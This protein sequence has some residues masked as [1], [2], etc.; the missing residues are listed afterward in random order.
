MKRERIYHPLDLVYLLTLVVTP[1]TVVIFCLGI[2]DNCLLAFF[3]R[4][5]PGPFFAGELNNNAPLLTALALP[6]LLVAGLYW[7]FAP[8]FL[9]HMSDYDNCPSKL[10][11]GI[12]FTAFYIRLFAFVPC[13]GLFFRG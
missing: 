1:V 4:L 5:V 8:Y 7:F 2:L 10:R 12:F 9:F 11:K 6:E 3:L 13:I